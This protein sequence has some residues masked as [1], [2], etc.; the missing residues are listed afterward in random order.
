M[1]GSPAARVRAPSVLVVVLVAALAPVLPASSQD[2]GYERAAP[3]APMAAQLPPGYVD[4]VLLGGLETPTAFR[5]APDGRLLIAEKSGVIKV[6]D[7]VDD[8]APTVSTGLHVNVHNYADRGLLGMALD[9]D[10]PASPYVYVLYAYDHQPGTPAGQVPRW[11]NGRDLS[12]PCPPPSPGAKP[13][14]AIDGRLSRLTVA[15][16]GTVGEEKPLIDDGWCFQYSS[17]GTG[18]VEF[19]PDGYLYASAGE[20]ASFEVLDAGVSGSCNDPAGEGGS[21]RSQDLRTSGDPLGLDGTVIRVDKTTGAGAP[22]NPLAGSAD[23]NARRIVAQGLRNPFRFTVRRAADGTIEVYVL[24]VGWRSA[25]EVDRFRLGAA[26]PANFGWPCYEGPERNAAWDA[27]DVGICEGLYAE[28]PGAVQAPFFHYL[29]GQPIFPGDTCTRSSGSAASALTFLP[30]DSPYPG[31]LD[32]ALLVGDYARN[33]L[34][35]HPALAGGDPDDGSPT[36]FAQ[37]VGTPVMLQ[38]GPGGEIHYLEIF[39][40]ASGVGRLHRIRYNQAPEALVEADR[41][42]GPAPLTVRLDGSRSTDSTD[43]SG[44]LGYAWDLDADGAFDDSDQPR[45]TW[46]YTDGTANVPVRLRVTDSAGASDTADLELQPGNEPPVPVI[47]TPAGMS[48]RPGDVVGFAGAATDG[49]QGT[50]PPESLAWSLTTRHCPQDG[51][52]THPEGEWTG[53]SGQFVVAEHERPSHLLL[54]LRATDE[55]GLSCTASVR[56][57]FAPAAPEPAPAPP[58]ECVARPTPTPD[59]SPPTPTPDPPVTTP[60]STRIVFRSLP[61]GIRMIVDGRRLRTGAGRRFEVGTRLV[62]VAPRRQR[63]RGQRW[64]FDGWRGHQR[65]RWVITVPERARTYQVRYRRGR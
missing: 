3:A 14:C 32:G 7:S 4:E 11:G 61:R 58:P 17:H 8:P 42:Y 60:D 44:S 41:T 20:G 12:D 43:S 64:V 24:D 31:P 55:R 2:R 40:E 5:F 33:C 37:G 15:A 1:L 21:L 26:Q 59:P 18:T 63:V 25:E 51:C 29:H 53:T 19:G 22:G 46:T 34:W 54:T 36:P 48:V 9:P 56:L 13:E 6:Y 65:R 28:G 57:D 16:D 35:S 52:H 39:D 23:P 50:L 62:V 30:E 47:S 45:P 27:A 10:F 49:Q 38:S